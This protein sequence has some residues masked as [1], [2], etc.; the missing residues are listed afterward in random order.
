MLKDKKNKA[1]TLRKYLRVV[2]ESY[3]IEEARGK[4]AV[5][6]SISHVFYRQV[7]KLGG[8]WVWP[9]DNDSVMVR[10][11]LQKQQ[12]GELHGEAGHAGHLCSICPDQVFQAKAKRNLGLLTE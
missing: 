12:G 7:E 6:L 1:A 10:M 9:T 5:M 2:A 3:L 8:G 11:I 4:R